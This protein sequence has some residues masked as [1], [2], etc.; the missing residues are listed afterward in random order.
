M[1]PYDSGCQT[2]GERLDDSEVN[3]MS[4]IAPFVVFHVN[5]IE[6]SFSLAF[7]MKSGILNKFKVR[8]SGSKRA[9]VI[10]L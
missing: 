3:A 8:D 2:Q 6:V 7:Q 4:G 9:G 5:Q 1:G 10:T